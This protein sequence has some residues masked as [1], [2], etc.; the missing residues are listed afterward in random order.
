ME[1][2][3]AHDGDEDDDDGDHAYD[4]GQG[5]VRAP[6]VL[7]AHPRPRPLGGLSVGHLVTA[8]S[9]KWTRNGKLYSDLGFHKGQYKDFDQTNAISSL[10][11]VL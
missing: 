4:G 8:V 3:W 1:A 7:G 9:E 2:D 10:C 11:G 6:L 5:G